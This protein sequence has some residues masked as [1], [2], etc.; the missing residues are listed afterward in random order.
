MDI[1]IE[2]DEL[3]LHGFPAADRYRIGDAVQAELAR[4]FAERGLPD[5]AMQNVTIGRLDGGSFNLAARM[6]VT[7]VGTGAAEAIYRAVTAVPDNH[8][9][10]A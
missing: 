3:V 4:I 7:A 8:G 10:I 5:M 6:P 1:V 2:I 9:A